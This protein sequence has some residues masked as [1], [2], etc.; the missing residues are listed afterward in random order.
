MHRPALL[1]PPYRQHR[2]A[3]RSSTHRANTILRQWG[4]Q[5]Y[6]RNELYGPHLVFCGQPPVRPPPPSPMSSAPPIYRNA[7]STDNSP[8]LLRPCPLLRTSLL[9]CILSSSNLE[10]HGPLGSSVS[11]RIFRG[12]L[13]SA[14]VKLLAQRNE[15]CPHCLR[16]YPPTDDGDDR[17]QEHLDECKTGYTCYWGCNTVCNRLTLEAHLKTCPS[18]AR[19]GGKMA[20]ALPGIEQVELQPIAGALWAGVERK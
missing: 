20:S 14:R 19:R 17:F 4:S 10:N 11:L 3:F 16:W 7:S 15:K 6:H 12:V 9:R 2:A 1:V 18:A 5:G 13:G 8:F